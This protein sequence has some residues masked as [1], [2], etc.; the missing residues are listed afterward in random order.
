MTAVHT[1]PVPGSRAAAPELLQWLSPAPLWSDESVGP[2]ASGLVQPWIAELTSDQFVPEFLGILAGGNGS[3]PADLA[4]TT[5]VR[6]VDG[7]VG[8]P[9][10]LFQ[11]LSQRYYMV[12]ASLVCRRP[13]IPDHSAKTAKGEK[14]TF[15][16]R[17][18]DL[19]G[20]ESAW[21]PAV[22][23]STSGALTAGA[24]PTGS[25]VPALPGALVEG[26]EQ[27]PMHAAPVAGFAEPGSTAAALGMA[28]NAPST[29]TVFYGYIPVGRRER[30]I[31]SLLDEEVL[32]RLSAIN[33]TLP[34]ALKSDPAADELVARVINP[35]HA[36]QTQPSPW[37]SA[38]LY[39]PWFG[40]LYWLLDLADWLNTYVH[41]LYTAI[42]NGTEMAAGARKTLQDSLGSINV[43]TSAPSAPRATVTLTQALV[44]LLPFAGLVSGADQAGPTTKYDLYNTSMPAGWATSFTDGSALYRLALAAK[45]EQQP[46]LKVPPELSGLIKDD[47]V[48]VAPGTLTPTYVIRTVFTHDPCQPVLSAATH[49]FVL[50]RAT[51]GDAPARKIRIQ[52]PDLANLRQFK[53]GV[54]LEMPPSMTSLIN[55]VTPDILK[56]SGL[57]D[58]SDTGLG[59][60]CSFSIQIIFMCAFIVLFIFLLLLNI[61]FWWMP[62]LKICFPVPVSKPQS[63]AP[64]P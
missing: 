12:A 8:A 29:R 62:F 53:R 42:L 17:Q 36:I 39:Y 23:S 35:L 55:R 3:S 10:T 44:D 34:D 46:T 51:D 21:V 61:V 33:A 16:M 30:M 22:G 49:A 13:G 60:I 1:R 25:W 45:A 14:A 31:P 6:T 48:Y 28:A 27:L 54:A 24:P 7:V 2:A 59:M 43:V 15:V 32:S 63:K 57:K 52:L 9:F 18:V 64:S 26:E 58:G 56:G 37:T 19:E 20:T 5:P 47:P 11:P 38:H 41:D 4:E 40:S 50:A